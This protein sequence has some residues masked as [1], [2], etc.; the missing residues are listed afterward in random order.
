MVNFY[1]LVYSLSMRTSVTLDDDV[2]EFASSYAH[3]RGMTLS[4]AIN[5]L[6]R[7]AESSPTPGPDILIGPNGLPMFP[8]SGIRIT[9]ELVK[10]LEEEEFDPKKFT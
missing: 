6:I 10:K 5:E 3:G 9:P 2:H 1:N 7:K 4:A 8:P